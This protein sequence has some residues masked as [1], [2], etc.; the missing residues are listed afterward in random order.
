MGN[1]PG[2]FKKGNKASKGKGRPP[3]SP[4]VRAI[5][6]L[7]TSHYI[8]IANKY[9]YL[10]EAQLKARLKDKSLT[11]LEK[12]VC[13]FVIQNI[14]SGSVSSLETLL[15]RLIGRVPAEVNIGS[16]TYLDFLDEL[17]N[18]ESK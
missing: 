3:T 10:N 1:R 16:G 15:Q 8:E 4:E 17:A 13:K 5:K 11:A 2:T 7:T 6:K 9:L 12:I 14:K 18:K